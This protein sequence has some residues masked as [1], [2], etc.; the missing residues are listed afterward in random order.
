MNELQQITNQFQSPQVVYV[1]GVS[2][3]GKSTIGQALA[4]ALNAA[5]YDGDDFHPAANIAKMQSGQA[6]NDEDRQA[7]LE[8][9]RQLV[10][11]K[12]T[13]EWMVIACSALKAKYRRVLDKGIEA[14]VHWIFLQGSYELILGRMQKRVGHF[15]PAA[16]L[17]SQF[18]SLEIPT[19][20]LHC[21]IENSPSQII[22]EI[23]DH[24]SNTKASFGLIG[25]GVMG[26]SLSRNLARNGFQLALYNRHVPQV[27][28]QVAER[29]IA[30]FPELERAKGFE[31]LAAFVQAQARPRKI[32][33]MIKAGA[34]VDSMIEQLLPLLET[35][36]VI[37]DGGNAHYKETERRNQLLA[38]KGIL[39]VGTG[40]SGGEEGALKG[41]SIMP[42]GS[43]AAYQL[44][45][46]YLEKIAAKDV[47]QTTCCAHIGEGGAGHFVK[48]VH[49]GIEYAEM[50]LIAEC[51]A[52]LRWGTKL[53]P[54]EI[55]D[56]F[57]EWRTKDLDSYLLKISAN[58]LR[59][60]EGESW[61]L[62]QILDQAGNKGTGSWTTIAA[63][64]LGIPVP[65]ISAAL[66]ARYQ[67][68]FKTERTEAAQKY[69]T[70]Y[71]SFGAD[72]AQLEQAYRLAR[73]INHHQGF[74]LIVAASENH[75][76][77][78]QLSELARIWTNGCIIRST[79][80]QQFI[81][82]LQE[83]SMIL[84]APTMIQVVRDNWSGL[85]EVVASAAY[86][87][88]SIPCLSSA[89]NYLQTYTQS[90]SS[91]N[92]IQAQRDYFG[93]H[94]YQR[95]DDPKGKAH[96]TIWTTAS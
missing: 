28:E 64:E 90:Q 47:R 7:W 94:T 29:F 11:Q 14:S 45:Q 9:I 49:N 24:L 46:P 92:L 73:I 40:V 54:N 53:P 59:K 76:W 80:M 4:N 50:Q 18:D 10:E 15:M 61:L 95:V 58:I 16:L 74:H 63:C 57:S 5:F 3:C 25:L 66:F 77:N 31:D 88:I 89:L 21:N 8:A 39:F 36:D 71:Q 2:G 38:D 72:P 65:T 85:G 81:D 20:A 12:R 42:G 32:F 79:L 43:V 84:Q 52:L 27:E 91:A 6:L 62:D 93:A 23:M 83:E 70:S 26:K 86:A 1:M 22:Q 33:L 19:G 75:Q 34:A 56:L 68:A 60:K 51:Y 78:I 35:G 17:Q 37:I 67:S 41:P 13:N 87:G 48:M 30:Q 44:V 82:V 69:A 96:H 55:A